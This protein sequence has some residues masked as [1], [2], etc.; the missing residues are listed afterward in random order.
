MVNLHYSFSLVWIAMITLG[1]SCCIVTV[2]YSVNRDCL[3]YNWTFLCSID[4]D[5]MNLSVS[6]TT[7]SVYYTCGELFK[8]RSVH[9]RVSLDLF[10]ELSAHGLM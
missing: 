7:C 6:P 4:H 3:C 1:I 5:I 10:N 9:E 2:Q 8:L